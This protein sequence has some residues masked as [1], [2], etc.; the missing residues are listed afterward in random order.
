M[1]DNRNKKKEDIF[2]KRTFLK[3]IKKNQKKSKNN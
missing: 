2:K 1:I 3:K